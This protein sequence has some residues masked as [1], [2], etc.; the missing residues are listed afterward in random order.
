[1]YT[2]F[3]SLRIS[4]LEASGSEKTSASQLELNLHNMLSPHK[5]FTEHGKENDRL[6][7]EM[8]LTVMG[9]EIEIILKINEL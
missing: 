1:M 8:K 3:K 9:A 2:L 5:R 6:A 4:Q 7:A